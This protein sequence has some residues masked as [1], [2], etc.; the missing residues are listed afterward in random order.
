MLNTSHVMESPPPGKTQVGGLITRLRRDI[1][2]GVLTPGSRLKI[3]EVAERYDAGVI[4]TREALSRLVSSGLVV[5]HEQRG[6]RVASISSEELLDLASLRKS[7]ETRALRES[8]ENG[9]LEWETRLIAAHHRL[10][11]LPLHA[12]VDDPGFG[13]DWVTAHREFHMALLSACKSKW[14]MQFVDVL[15]DQMNRYRQLSM[16]SPSDETRD[17]P[18]EHKALLDAA[19]AHDVEAACSL[20][21]EHFSVTEANVLSALRE[22]MVRS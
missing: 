2:A 16:P 11:R 22:R 17:V 20:L 13:Q 9:N 5:A 3:N 14:L 21:I 18:G 4:P 12:D 6:F 19:L 1:I 8:M 15:S 7:L 10:S